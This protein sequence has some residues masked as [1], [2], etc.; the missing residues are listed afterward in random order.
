MKKEKGAAI[1]VALFVVALVAAMS[2]LMLVRISADLRRTELIQNA[3]QAYFLAEG[4]VAWAKDTLI[5]NIDKKKP[6]QIVDNTPIQS[7]E[8][9][10]GNAKIQ[11]TIYAAEGRFNINNLTK[12][13]EDKT[14]LRLLRVSDPTLSQQNAQQILLA[15]RDWISGSSN[16]DLENYYSKQNP[17]FKAPHR[18]MAS[19]SEIR[20]VKGMTQKLYEALIPYIIALPG[21]TSINVNNADVPVLMSLSETLKPEAAKT[22]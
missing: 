13:E 16:L 17:P 2:T 15:V 20:L 4:S 1:I 11:S 9:T 12:A 21:E 7:P 19:A 22:I 6:N 10:V 18:L 8:N 3:S 5:T 14:F